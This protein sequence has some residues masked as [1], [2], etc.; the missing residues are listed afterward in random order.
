MT[1]Y[2]YDGEQTLVFTGLSHDGHTLKAVPGETYDL[3]ST[4]LLYP[5]GEGVNV[6]AI[7]ATIK[8]AVIH[9]FVDECF[10]RGQIG[11][12]LGAMGGVE[13]D[14]KNVDTQNHEAKAYDL[15]DEFQQYWGRS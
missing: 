14:G 1:L 6:S 9:F 4:G 8:S 3:D 10:S 7:P 15:L 2:K 13:A 12:S 5:H 11:V